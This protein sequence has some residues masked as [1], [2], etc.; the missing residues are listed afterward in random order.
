MPDNSGNCNSLPVRRRKRSAGASI[1]LPKP[2]TAQLRADAKERHDA[3]CELIEL[4]LADSPVTFDGREWA[5]PFAQEAVANTLGM[6]VRTLQRL[7]K[8]S[9]VVM[10]AAGMG[11]D[12][13]VYFRLGEAGPLSLRK[14]AN[15]LSKVWRTHVGRDMTTH[16]E[17]GLLFGLAELWPDGKQVKV[18]E[19][20]LRFWS[21]FMGATKLEIAAARDLRRHDHDPFAPDLL[22]DPLYETARRVP[23][24]TELFHRH[25]KHPNLGFLRRFQH[26]ALDLWEA[27]GRKCRNLS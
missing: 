23:T 4:S 3:L 19:H 14:V 16:R 1:A 2:A 9:P 13:G 6:S 15:T 11:A 26:I 27:S 7:A 10:T 12:K 24:D 22:A 18:F 25:Y 20:T 5:G 21:E 17:Y 8:V